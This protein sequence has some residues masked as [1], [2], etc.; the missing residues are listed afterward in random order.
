RT[1]SDLASYCRAVETLRELSAVLGLFLKPPAATASA[2]EDSLPDDLM[3]LIIELRAAARKNKDFATADL[4]RD[5]L[6]KV[7]VTL[8]DRKDGTGWKREA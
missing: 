7:G 5:S 4:I 3:R 6:T 2:G 1:E 8:E